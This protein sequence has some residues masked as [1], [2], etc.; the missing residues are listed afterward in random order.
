VLLTFFFNLIILNLLRVL[1]KVY[2]INR[3]K[4]GLGVTNILIVGAGRPGRDIARTLKKYENVG[5]RLIGFVDDSAKNRKNFP[6]IGKLKDLGNL[7]KKHKI[8]EVYFTNPRLSYEDILSVSSIFKGKDLSFKIATNL[9]SVFNKDP[10]NP[11]PKEIPSLDLWKSNSV[12]IYNLFKRFIDLFISIFLIILTFPFWLII[13]IFIILED[14][15]PVIIKLKRAGY[16]GRQ[17]L[18]YKFRTM[19]KDTD[20][21]A[22]A[23]RSNKDNR[24]TK[25]GR[26]LRKTSLDEL[27]QLI[28]IILGN[29][30]LV[31]PRPEIPKIVKKYSKW[32]KLRLE[33][34]PGLTGLWQV[35]GR[36]DLPLHENIEYDFYYI[37]NQTLLMDL[38]ILI[39]TIPVVLLGRGAY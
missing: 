1:Y 6:V 12:F 14:G 30:S 4:R 31:G 38:M 28:N 13:S 24:V 15:F 21:S 35:L 22:S 2:E 29:M 3:F 34:K 8:K 36:K 16:K 5:Y 7:I 27:P 37:N 11:T 39:K 20:R 32:Q 19:K 10:F 33:T 26:T 18:I 17:F 25:V 23:P 9:F